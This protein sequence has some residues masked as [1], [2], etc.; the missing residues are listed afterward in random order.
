MEVNLAQVLLSLV[1]SVIGGGII[2]AWIELQ[3]HRHEKEEWKL[4]EKN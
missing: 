3:R 1:S 2:L 4:K